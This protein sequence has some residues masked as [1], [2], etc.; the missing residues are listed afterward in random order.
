MKTTV[1]ITP[2]AGKKQTKGRSVKKK[3]SS[4]KRKQDAPSARA[5]TR[6]TV[7]DELRFILDA[8]KEHRTSLLKD[9]D[10]GDKNLA[11]NYREANN[12]LKIMFAVLVKMLEI[13][14][15][16]DNPAGKPTP[17]YDREMLESL[18]M[19]ELRQ[20]ATGG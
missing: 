17:H 20:L 1:R 16:P 10:L 9:A 18:S 19:E 13:D 8:C 7:M 14:D 5:K 12:A 4:V 6:D 11:A 15:A 2:K 3:T